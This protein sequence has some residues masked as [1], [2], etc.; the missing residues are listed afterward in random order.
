MNVAK[1]SNVNINQR[2]QAMPL[3]N[4]KGYWVAEELHL[5]PGS[6]FTVKVH[7]PTGPKDSANPKDIC[8]PIVT[9]EGTDKE[10][11]Q[12]A[13]CFGYSTNPSIN[14]QNLIAELNTLFAPSKYSE[15]SKE[16]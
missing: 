2:A 14:A 11:F 6:E 10:G 1:I 9:V 15:Y 5:E 7:A 4:F 3:Q 12:V 8:E 13:G 16:V